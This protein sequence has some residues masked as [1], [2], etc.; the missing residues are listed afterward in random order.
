MEVVAAGNEVDDHL[1]ALQKLL[2]DRL[3]MALGEDDFPLRRRQ[4]R[5]CPITFVSFS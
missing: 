2:G 5:Y 1:P 4:T 3:P